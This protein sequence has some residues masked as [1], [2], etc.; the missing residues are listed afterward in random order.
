VNLGGCRGQR[1]KAFTTEGTEGMAVPQVGVAEVLRTW[2]S[3]V[4]NPYKG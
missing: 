1:R 4:L 2:G 3:A